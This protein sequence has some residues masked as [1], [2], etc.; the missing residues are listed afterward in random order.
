MSLTSDIRNTMSG[1]GNQN[2]DCE[3]MDHAGKPLH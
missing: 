3:D 1:T 2:T